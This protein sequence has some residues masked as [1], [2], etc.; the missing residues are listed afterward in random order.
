MRSRVARARITQASAVC[1]TEGH[2]MRARRVNRQVRRERKADEKMTLGQICLRDRRTRSQQT[3]RSLATKD[4]RMPRA[5][6]PR[7]QRPHLWFARWSCLHT[8]SGRLCNR[9]NEA[10]VLATQRHSHAAPPGGLL[11]IALWLFL[12]AAKLTLSG[13]LRNRH[14]E[15][16]LLATQRRSHGAPPGAAHAHTHHNTHPG[17]A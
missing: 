10:G 7:T 1:I 13:Q 2:A 14:N 11:G 16:G 9:H 4:R 8:I 5:D 12:Q 15:A 3:A 17:L 6:S